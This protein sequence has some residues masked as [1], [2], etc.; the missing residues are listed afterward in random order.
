MEAQIEIKSQIDAGAVSKLGAVQVKTMMLKDN[1]CG[2]SKQ[3][4]ARQAAL[5]DRVAHIDPDV[6][7][8]VLQ[9]DAT[10]DLPQIRDFFPPGTSVYLHRLCE[11]PQAISKT[12]RANYTKDVLR[13]VSS[14]IWIC[15]RTSPAGP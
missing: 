11:R 14:S 9:L 12:W 13:D 4:I 2:V 3:N 15:R 5:I 1:D 10:A 6:Y 7:Q 8:R